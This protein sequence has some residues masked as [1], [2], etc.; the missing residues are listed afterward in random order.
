MDLG[1]V[2]WHF[3]TLVPWYLGTLVPWY[4]GTWVPWHLCTWPP[5]YLG[6][7]VPWYQGTKVPWYLGALV[8]WHLLL[9]L[10]AQV[11]KGKHIARSAV[12]V[13]RVHDEE[14]ALSIRWNPP[15]HRLPLG[16][17]L[18]LGAC[19][20]L[21][22]AP[23]VKGFQLLRGVLFFIPWKTRSSVFSGWGMASSTSAWCVMVP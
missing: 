21:F 15:P 6:T 7:L 10:R 1:T 14:A 8:P 5:R 4:L 12:L 23:A 19:I 11:A 20:V 3:G 18:S 17:V 16:S 9:A 22:R 13:L 2:A